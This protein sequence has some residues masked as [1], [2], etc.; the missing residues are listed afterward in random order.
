M[1]YD[2]YATLSVGVEH[3][4][5]WVTI[6]HPPINLLDLALIQDLDRVGRELEA[7][8][9]RARGRLP[10]R[11]P[12]LLHRARRRHADPAAADGAA[13]EDRDELG[14][15]HQMVERF[16]T[17][18]KATIGVDRGARPRR[19]QRVPALAR[20]ALRRARARL[21]AQPEV[22]LGIIP[23]GSGTQRLPR[24]IGRARALEVIL[25]CGDFPADLAERWGY[26]PRPAA[27]R[28]RPFVDALARRI[29]SFPAEAIALA[30]AAVDAAELPTRGAARRGAPLQPLARHPR[31][32]D[33]HGEVHGGRGTDPGSREGDRHGTGAVAADGEVTGLGVAISWPPAVWW[34]RRSGPRAPRR[35]R[36]DRRMEAE[37]RTRRAA[38]RRR[39]PIRSVG[40]VHS[41]GSTAACAR[42]V[43][44]SLS[45]SLKCPISAPQIAAGRT[46]PAPRPFWRRT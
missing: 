33:A 29:A 36:I 11:Q 41:P 8:D 24:L 1:S 3:G 35:R 28:A 27:G 13:A 42:P 16:R 14:L 30:K 20:H 6:D 17:M 38:I 22:A 45:A 32:T 15:F 21:L 9:A 10:E 44:V 2:G 37:T 18:P 40:S 19:R 23:G 25:G 31:G 7:D 46:P 26:Q 4:V 43:V 39:S 12:R 5:A 34:P